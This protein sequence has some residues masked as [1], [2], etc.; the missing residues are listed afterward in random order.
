MSR[1][2]SPPASVGV[3]RIPLFSREGKALVSAS[4]LL[5]VTSDPESVEGERRELL[6]AQGRSGGTWESTDPTTTLYHRELTCLSCS[7]V[8]HSREEQVQHY[9]L[10]WHRYNLKRKLKGLESVNQDSFETIAGIIITVHQSCCNGN[11]FL[12]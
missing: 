5:G 6:Q 8:L 2:N 4:S 7:E 12:K 10:D 1:S 9:K 11:W 3:K